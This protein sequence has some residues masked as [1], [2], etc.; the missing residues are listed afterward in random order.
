MLFLP[1]KR[2]PTYLAPQVIFYQNSFYKTI[3]LPENNPLRLTPAQFPDGGEAAVQAIRHQLMKYTALAREVR[4]L[5]LGVVGTSVVD[6]FFE[7]FHQSIDCE[8]HVDLLVIWCKY[9]EFFGLKTDLKNK[10]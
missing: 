4:L 8:S 5:R 10:F 6:Y 9:K 1:S 7:V 2:E 3:L